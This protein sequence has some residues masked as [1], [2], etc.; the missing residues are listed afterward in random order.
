[1]MAK[2]KCE[3]RAIPDSSAGYQGILLYCIK[4]G[5]AMGYDNNWNIY[6]LRED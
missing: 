6:P 1:M 4:C 5:K 2:H 3:Y